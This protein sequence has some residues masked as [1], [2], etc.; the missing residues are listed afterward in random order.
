MLPRCGW[1]RRRHE[2]RNQFLGGLVKTSNVP[3]FRASRPRPY[4]WPWW[5]AVARPTVSLA[6]KRV[7]WLPPSLAV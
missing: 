5:W 2:S 7:D 3:A 1:A 4:S 6:W